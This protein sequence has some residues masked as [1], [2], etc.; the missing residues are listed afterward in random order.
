MIRVTH[1]RAHQS[2]FVICLL[3]S[4]CAACNRS[5]PASSAGPSQGNATPSAAIKRYPFKGKI[6]SVDSQ[7]QSASV[8]GE[9]IPG[10]MSAMT[11]PYEIRPTVDLAKLHVG[12]SITAEVVVDNSDSNNEKYWLENVTVTSISAQKP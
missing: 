6:V 4:F 8:A 12:D 7:S 2:V 10:F 1:F 9:D 3:L 11:M 5:T